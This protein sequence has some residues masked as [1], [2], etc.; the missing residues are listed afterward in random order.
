MSLAIEIDNVSAVLLS[1]G[2]WYSVHKASFFLD[3]YEF[4]Q[5]ADDERAINSGGIGFS[6]QCKAEKG[7]VEVISGPFASIEA[8]KTKFKRP[9][10]K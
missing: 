9:I 1:D 2:K 5:S 8:V 6:F 4:L 7:E 3:A 10:T